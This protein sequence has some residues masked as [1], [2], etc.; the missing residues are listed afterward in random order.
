MV[1]DLR[2]VL[3]YHDRVCLRK[4]LFDMGVIPFS[5]S[6]AL[7]IVTTFLNILEAEPVG[8]AFRYLV[9]IFVGW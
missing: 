5:F 4:S 8:S 6:K 7:I 2:V 9:S 1:I 3:V